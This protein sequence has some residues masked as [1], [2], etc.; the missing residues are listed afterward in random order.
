MNPI[1]EALA[2]L[3][4]HSHLLLAGKEVA[5][6]ISG[7]ITSV[8]VTRTIA[9]APTLAIAMEDPDRE[10]LQSGVFGHKTTTHLSPFT[11]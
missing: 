9:G 2:S 7:S 6:N 1:D 11:Y 4:D 8:T 3:Q 10:V 5:D